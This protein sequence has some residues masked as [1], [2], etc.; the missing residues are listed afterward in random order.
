MSN[1]D[2][3][4]T[5][6]IFTS[7]ESVKEQVTLDG[8]RPESIGTGT[9]LLTALVGVPIWLTV[10]LPLSAAYQVGK[11]ILPSS[12]EVTENVEPVE[13]HDDEDS[14]PQLSDIKPMEDRKYDVV[15]LGATGFTGKIAAKYLAS[16]YGNGG[17]VK[18]A[19]AGRSQQKLDDLK[20][21][22]AKEL[23]ND[24]EKKID[25]IIVDTSVRSSIHKLVDDTRVVIST[26]GP[27]CKYG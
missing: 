5:T 18:W 16:R 1:K 8:K 6:N 9:F 21:D 23:G 10:L 20:K 17:G 15:L 14:F 26:A 7:I 3:Q 13:L 25:S 24:T 22:I 12:S 11:S 27:F 19:I 4:S 2:H